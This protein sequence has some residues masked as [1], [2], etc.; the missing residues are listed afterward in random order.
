MMF[1]CNVSPRPKT[2]TNRFTTNGTH[3]PLRSTT[4]SLYRHQATCPESH[5][6]IFT[7]IK[8]TL[9]GLETLAQDV[10][11]SHLTGSFKS[12]KKKNPYL[13]IKFNGNVEHRSTLFVCDWRRVTPSSREINP[14]WNKASYNLLQCRTNYDFASAL[15]WPELRGLACS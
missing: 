5:Q 10:N 6:V 8:K 3:E 15:E 4:S 12:Y 14:S 9:L 7:P 13:S 2:L 11:Q 1:K